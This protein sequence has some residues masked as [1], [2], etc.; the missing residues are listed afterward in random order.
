LL[1]LRYSHREALGRERK[2]DVVKLYSSYLLRCWRSGEEGEVESVRLQHI[3]S[4][5]VIRVASLKE[6][7]AWLEEQALELPTYRTH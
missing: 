3:Q 4:G 6:A 1:G 7:L 2:G 5:E